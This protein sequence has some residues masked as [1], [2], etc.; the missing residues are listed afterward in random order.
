MEG[1]YDEDPGPNAG[2][3]STNGLLARIGRPPG[4]RA[5][6]LAIAGIGWNE[7]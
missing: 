2:C 4:I 1:V 5:C 3:G 6:T 7:T